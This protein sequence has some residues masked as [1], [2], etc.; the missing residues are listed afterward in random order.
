[1]QG[2]M[3]PEQHLLKLKHECQDKLMQIPI[4]VHTSGAHAQLGYI[5]GQHSTL[6]SCEACCTME[7]QEICHN[8]LADLPNP[9]EP[10]V[11]TWCHYPALS[12]ASTIESHAYLPGHPGCD[13]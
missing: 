2:N 3:L 7:V 10:L 8:A 11:P 1:M 9:A 13:E 12:S 6:H 5:V 4:G